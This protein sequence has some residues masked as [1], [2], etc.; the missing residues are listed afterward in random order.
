[1]WDSRRGEAPDKSSRLGSA[2]WGRRLGTEA[3][4]GGRLA[5]H[6]K[7]WHHLCAGTMK[8]GGGGRKAR[9]W[10]HGPGRRHEYFRLNWSS[11]HRILSRRV[12]DFDSPLA[13]LS[14]MGCGLE[15]KKR[16]KGRRQLLYC[17]PGCGVAREMKSRQG[18]EQ[19]PL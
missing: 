2:E 4:A 15:E 5:T 18:L 1:M 3:P 6:N 10:N 9:K 16:E 13:A 17:R 12:A 7:G 8:A 14:R 19:D 11:L